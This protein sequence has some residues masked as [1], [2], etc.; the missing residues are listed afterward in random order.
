MNGV[1]TVAKVDI[2]SRMSG[3]PFGVGQNGLDGLEGGSG[4][5][6][7]RLGSL[8][9]GSGRLGS[10]LEGGLGRLLVA[11]DLNVDAAIAAALGSRSAN[12]AGAAAVD[13]D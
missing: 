6:E 8:E 11:S 1:R 2:G 13:L 10:G 9:S 3:K 4:R 5:L 7:G 12:D